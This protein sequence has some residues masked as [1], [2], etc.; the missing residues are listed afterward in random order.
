MTYVL[1]LFS[2]LALVFLLNGRSKNL[3]DEESHDDVALLFE[4]IWCAKR[5]LR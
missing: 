3:L 5:K 4:R 2:V 1:L